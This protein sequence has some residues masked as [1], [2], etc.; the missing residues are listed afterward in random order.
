MTKSK[1]ALI[2]SC[3]LLYVFNVS[4][5]YK[6]YRKNKGNKKSPMP[7]FYIGEH[8]KHLGIPLIPV[9]LRGIR[10]ISRS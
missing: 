9:I 10:P 6:Q 2:D 3:V 4:R 5:I 7:D 8:A 1:Q